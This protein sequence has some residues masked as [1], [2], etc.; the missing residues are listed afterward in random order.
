[1]RNDGSAV[2]TDGLSERHNGVSSYYSGDLLGSIEDTTDAS[3]TSVT[4]HTEDDA[5]CS[6]VAQGG[7]TP[8]PFQYCGREGYQTDK[9]SGLQLL[10]NRYY[11]PVIGRFLTRDPAEAGDNW[12]AYAGNNPVSGSDPSGLLPDSID[13]RKLGLAHGPQAPA[14]P[15]SQAPSFTVVG[16]YRIFK[17]SDGQV[18]PNKAPAFL[19]N[20]FIPNYVDPDYNMQSAYNFRNS[21]DYHIFN[22]KIPIPTKGTN[23]N[24]WY[25]SHVAPRQSMDYKQI[26]L[27]HS[28]WF[29]AE[30]GYRS[31]FD[32]FGN[33]NAGSVGSALGIPLSIIQAGAT[34]QHDITGHTF[35]PDDK[36][37]QLETQA[38]YI[39]ANQL[40]PNW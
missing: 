12:Y 33:F 40:H 7:S 20:I 30:M 32:A 2:Y 10:G 26:A 18:D 21:M 11:D 35:A 22:Y 29:P 5:F 23:L 14:S 1:L 31:G 4:S 27:A 3:G 16:V 28:D 34:I 8:S 24:I 37:G 9:D 6:I 39:Y 13:G 17:N 38:G 25:L 15:Y 19:F 36:S